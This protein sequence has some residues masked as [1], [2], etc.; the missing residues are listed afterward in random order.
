MKRIITII[1]ALVAMASGMEV[2]AADESY[3]VYNNGALTFYHDGLRSSRTGMTYDLNTGINIPGWQADGNYANVTSVLFDSSFKSARPTTTYSWFDGMKKIVSIGGIDNLNTSD[4][5]NMECMF[6]GCSSLKNLNLSHFDT[7][8][9]TGM[10]GMF[11]CCSSLTSLTVSSFDTSKVTDMGEMFLCCSSLTSL[12]VNNFDTSEVT[13]MGSMFYGCNSLTS[14][15]LSNFDTSNVTYISSMFLGCKSLT[16]LD[17]S[18]FDTSKVT[19]M[20][21]MFFFCNNLIRLDVS[22]FDTSNVTSMDGLFS[23]CSKLTTVY[24]GSGWSTTNVTS[25]DM[26]TDCSAIKGEQGTTYDDDHTDAAYAH[27]DGGSANPGYLTSVQGT[28]MDIGEAAPLKDK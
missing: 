22:S 19:N 7:S 16:S 25:S 26:F 15:D 11:K 9:V 17:M 5:T 14:L 28:V 20:S 21:G 12:D 13:S 4:V 2:M 27:V 6:C 8:K 18:N 10:F 23:G 1:V 3:A 24:V